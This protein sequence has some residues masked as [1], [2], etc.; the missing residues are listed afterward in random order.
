MYV[1]SQHFNFF[2]FFL[3]F[4]LVA[5]GKDIETGKILW[6]QR[7]GSFKLTIVVIVIPPPRTDQ[8]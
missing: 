4:F 8:N 1:D 7:R 5:L 2:F 6:Q 3:N